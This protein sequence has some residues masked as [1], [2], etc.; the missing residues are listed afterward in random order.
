[1]IAYIF[2]ILLHICLIVICILFKRQNNYLTQENKIIVERNLQVEE[3]NKTLE[4]KREQLTKNC[5]EL[6]H[7][8]FQQID[9]LDTIK[10][11]IAEQS[12]VLNSLTDTSKKMQAEAKD[13]AKEV[14]DLELD[15]INKD[16]AN[17]RN[18]GTLEIQ[19]TLEEIQQQVKQEQDKLNDLEAKQL[20]YIQA[21]QRAEEI[22]AQQDYYRMVINDYD[23][24]EIAML[25]K[26]Q[27]NFSHKEAIDKLIWE[28]YYKPAYD[29][30]MSHLFSITGKVSGVY[31][32][33]NLENGQAY[34][35]QSVDIRE[36]F[37]THIKTGLSHSSS[38]NKLYQQ[39]KQYR[40]ENFT[41]EILEIVD[42]AKLNEREAYW[43]DFYKTKDF[44]MNGTKGN[45]A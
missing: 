20:A 42:R 21:Q 5:N 2:L 10:A 37:R 38:N 27:I 25:R 6:E 22:K 9:K 17:K 32:I 34:I 44:G 35:G 15:K 41:F 16:L 31:K 36:R 11:N 43:I 39:M 33:T 4:T 26:L 7:N 1:M 40:P 29:L 23:I 18:Q 13:K 12:K 28:V 8:Y 3:D 14:Y 45:I 30:L 24:E 19:K